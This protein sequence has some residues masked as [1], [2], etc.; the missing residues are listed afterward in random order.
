MQEL[1]PAGI[2]RRQSWRDDLVGHRVNDRFFGRNRFCVSKDRSEAISFTGNADMTWPTHVK[3]IWKVWMVGDENMSTP[4][5]ETFDRDH[6]W[7]TDR[8]GDVKFIVSAT[9]SLIPIFDQP[10]PSGGDYTTCLMRLP[11]NA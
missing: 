8:R 10:V 7:V 11:C 5:R 9:K 2:A 4:L 1:S 3:P 6:Q